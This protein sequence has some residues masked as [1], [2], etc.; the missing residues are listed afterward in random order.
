MLPAWPIDS[1]VASQYL[2]ACILRWEHAVDHRPI[3]L[4]TTFGKGGLILLQ[5]LTRCSARKTKTVNQETG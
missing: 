4:Q 3:W 1:Q 5:S 2:A